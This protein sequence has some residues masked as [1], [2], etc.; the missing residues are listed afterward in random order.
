MTAEDSDD[1]MEDVED[2]IPMQGEDGQ[3]IQLPEQSGD[4]GV[5]PALIPPPFETA[6]D[7]SSISS[8]PFE[9]VTSY[10]SSSSSVAYFNK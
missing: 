1:D 7:N 10:S 8:E 9:P 6:Y 4:Q 2:G 5:R 3:V